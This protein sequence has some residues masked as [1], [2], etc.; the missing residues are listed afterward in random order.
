MIPHD[1]V[2]R[3]P[4][5]P[6]NRAFRLGFCTSPK[7]RPRFAINCAEPKKEHALTSLPHHQTLTK[8]QPVHPQLP[9]PS[10]RSGSNGKPSA[11]LGDDSSSL[12]QT[13]PA[14]PSGNSKMR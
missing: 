1:S 3:L 10:N 13:C 8:C 5:S 12:A 14:T 7:R 4:P 9:A 11:S 6:L 2:H